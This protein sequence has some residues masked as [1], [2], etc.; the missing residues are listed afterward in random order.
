MKIFMKKFISVILT[1]ALIVSAFTMV[2]SAANVTT[3]YD[4]ELNTLLVPNRRTELGWETTDGVPNNWHVIK[5]GLA[6]KYMA[7]TSVEETT[8]MGRYNFARWNAGKEVEYL[9]KKGYNCKYGFQ[10]KWEIFTNAATSGTTEVI[11]GNLRFVTDYASTTIKLYYLDDCIATLET[12]LTPGSTDFIEVYALQ[13]YTVTYMDGKLT[14]SRLSDG[15]DHTINKGYGELIKYDK[16]MVWTLPDG[17]ETDVIPM[18]NADFGFVQLG[19]KCSKEIGHPSLNKGVP[20]GFISQWNGESPIFAQPRLFDSYGMGYLSEIVDLFT[21]LSAD[22]PID[23]YHARKYYT[24]IVNEG[25]SGLVSTIRNYESYINAAEKAIADRATSS[26]DITATAGGNI[27]CNNKAFVNDSTTN[28]IKPGEIRTFKAV[29]N[30]GYSFAYWADEKGAVVSYDS[31]FDVAFSEVT[32]LKAVFHKDS[33]AAGK[34]ITVTFRDHAGNIVSSIATTSGAKV[35]LPALPFSFGY[36]IT[37]W[38]INGVEYEAGSSVAFTAD[39]VISVAANKET[40]VYNVIVSG[41]TVEIDNTF[42]YN[43]LIEVTFDKNLLKLG[44]N[45]G[46]WSNGKD[47][48]SYNENY[49]FFVGSDVEITAII[50][51]D[52][53]NITPLI[54][55]TD[56]SIINGGKMVSFLTE[57]YLP[58]NCTFIDAGTIYTNDVACSS[59]L[60]LSTVNGTSIR[61]A[62]TKFNTANGQFRL[63]LGSRSGA[64]TFY[65]VA[66]LSYVDASGIYRTA[67]TPVYSAS[68]TAANA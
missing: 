63:N 53:V 68:S 47:I 50:T 31:T 60:Y 21:G 18:E 37:G 10:Y 57:R 29:P 32:I 28:I 64:T 30:V 58:S 38:M 17:T 8:V 25:S 26:Y 33:T 9:S 13:A 5:E 16:N 48:V 12:G 1:V 56:V 4:A 51:R 20:G 34:D 23:V 24:A 22:S 7:N 14:V 11:M 27:Y 62:S 3:D 61:K 43:S 41:S 35:T 59:M 52:T 42:T 49:S 67:Y 6:L 55:V 45:F 46:G 40:T 65:A 36:N 15:V 39:T 54:S 44:E 66:Y 19:F 2:A